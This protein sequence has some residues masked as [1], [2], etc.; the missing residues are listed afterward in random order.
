MAELD[1]DDKS[2]GLEGPLD[3]G[4]SGTRPIES[5]V[6]LLL[7]PE[8]RSRRSEFRGSLAFA[9]APSTECA[10]GDIGAELLSLSSK[11]PSMTL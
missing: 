11:S 5:L 8:V 1:E 10:T 7:D 9:L 6:P 4:E 2:D 3:A